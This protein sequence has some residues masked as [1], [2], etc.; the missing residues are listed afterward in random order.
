MLKA[1]LFERCLQQMVIL[2]ICGAVQTGLRTSIYTEWH[3]PL[4]SVCKHE[5]VVTNARKHELVAVTRKEHRGDKLN[6]LAQL[7]VLW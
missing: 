7:G 5:S 4:V 2:I 6:R 1:L 3:K